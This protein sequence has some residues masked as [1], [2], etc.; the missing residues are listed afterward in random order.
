MTSALAVLRSERVKFTTLRSQWITPLVAVALT[1][2]ITTLVNL[3]YGQV[4]HTP[5]EDPAGGIYYGL[6]FG[7][8]AV[9]CIGVLLLGQEFNTR[10]I[11][12]SLTAVPGAG[13]STAR[14][15]RSVP[16][17]GCWWGWSPP[18]AR[19]S[20]SPPPSA[21]TRPPRASGAASSPV[22]STTRCWWCS[23]SA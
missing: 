12:V 7:H 9:A 17:W 10:M 1:V 20:R 8:V 23:A 6:L 14:N 16:G 19:S 11:G 4:D 2:G 3:A 22:C 15:W 13:A 5:G 21:S 18:R